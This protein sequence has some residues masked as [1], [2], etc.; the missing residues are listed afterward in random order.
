M[1]EVREHG[2]RGEHESQERH[3]MH[4]VSELMH[5]G[6]FVEVRTM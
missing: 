3:A 2:F 5:D 6:G 1:A 4:A